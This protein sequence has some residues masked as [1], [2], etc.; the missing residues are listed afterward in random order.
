V[1][2]T[3]SDKTGDREWEGKEKR[4]SVSEIHGMLVSR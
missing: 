3:V 1:V 2:G 4:L